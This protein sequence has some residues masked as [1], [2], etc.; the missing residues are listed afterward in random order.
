MAINRLTRA[1]DSGVFRD[2]SW[3]ADLADFGRYNLIYGWNGTGKTTLSRIFR[4]LERRTSPSPGEIT[5]NVDGQDIPGNKFSEQHVSIRVFNRDFVSESVFPVG[6]S[7]VAPIFVLGKESVDKQKEVERLRSDQDQQQ[8]RLDAQ[9]RKKREGEKALDDFCKARASAIRDTLRSPGQNRFND[10]DKSHF[11]SRAVEMVSRADKDKHAVSENERDRLLAQSRATPRP[12][13]KKIVYQLPDLKA[14]AQTIEELLKKTV[15]STAVPSLKSD[16]PLSEWIREGLVLHKQH[17]SETC[18]FCEQSLPTA[19]VSVLEGHFNTQYEEFLRDIDQKVFELQKEHRST[20]AVELP[21]PAEFYEDLASD[22]EAA[23]TA[24]RTSL[25]AVRGYL[26]SIASRLQEKKARV[27]DVMSMNVT[28]PDVTA[29]VIDSVNDVIRRHNEATEQFQGRVQQARQQVEADSVSRDLD[30]FVSLETST[31][32]FDA[33]IEQARSELDRLKTEILRLEHE[34]MEHRK[35]AE[36]LNSDLRNYLGHGELSL[37]VKETGY[38]ITRNAIPAQR[39]SEGETTAIALLYFLKSLEDRRFDLSTAVVV[40]DDP[41]SSLDANALYLAFGFIR[42]R[43]QRAAELFILT[44]NFRL[45]RQVR[46]W[47]HHL[48]KQGKKDISQRPARFYMLDCEMKGGVRYSRIAGLDPLLEQFESEYHY[49]FARIHRAVGETKALPLEDSYTLP[50]IARRLV[51]MFL[52]FRRPDVSGELWE[53]FKTLSF[54]EAKKFRIL[55]FLHTHSHSD[56][57]EEPE[58]DPSALAEARPV[59]SDLLDLIKSEDIAH[60]SAM[61]KLVVPLVEEEE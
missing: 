33:P 23:G 35:P 28:P 30:E 32:S 24:F 20:L 4:A 54:D 12:R 58:H 56:A 59:L 7:T 18:L 50:N 48:P 14:S 6:G 44:H 34:I 29:N 10:Y 1:K 8:T 17:G 49:L 11:R 15:R 41:V 21:S 61:E 19:R 31:H 47:F 55:R 39:L 25:N 9:Q 2:F 22:F 60:F 53:K 40:L 36:D 52:A 42:E 38:I 43:T 3:P 5:L 46:N 37:E 45:F 27:F 13:L 51:E 57:I 16:A 26:E